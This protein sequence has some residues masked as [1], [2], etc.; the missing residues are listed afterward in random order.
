MQTGS[1][2]VSAKLFKIP[3]PTTGFVNYV[4][5]DVAASE[6]LMKT[7]GSQLFIGVDNNTVLDP[8]GPGRDSVRI[9]SNNAYTH[10]LVIADFDHIP[11]SGCG[12]WPAL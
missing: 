5:A 1:D 7:V 6:G 4:T 12:S 10:A 2:R 8:N 9:Q 11:G 3:D